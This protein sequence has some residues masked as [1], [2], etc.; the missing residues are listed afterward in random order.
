LTYGKIATVDW[1]IE[2]VVE[3]LTSKIVFE[4]IEIPKSQELWLRQ[5]HQEFHSFYE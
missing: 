5:T 3:S 1:I 2:V 4:Q